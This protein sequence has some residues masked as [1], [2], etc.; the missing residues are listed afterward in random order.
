MPYD[1]YDFTPRKV[2]VMI[3]VVVISRD[4][5]GRSAMPSSFLFYVLLLLPLLGGCCAV[6]SEYIFT[7]VRGNNTM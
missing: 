5:S 7:Y 6:F 2:L 1:V 4:L 3:G